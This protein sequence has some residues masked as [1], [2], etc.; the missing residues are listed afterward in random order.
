MERD[1]LP[2]FWRWPARLVRSGPISGRFLCERLFSVYPRQGRA[3][4]LLLS[5]GCG[6]VQASL[7]G[8]TASVEQDRALMRASHQVSRPARVAAYS[9]HSLQDSGG[10]TVREFADAS[11]QVFALAWNGPSLPNLQQI[12]GSHFEAYLHAPLR[13]QG[14]RGHLSVQQGPLV[15]ES[16]GRM[17]NFFGRAYLGD[18]IPAGVQL[19]EIR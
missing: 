2:G 13:H 10:G 4:A 14:G 6:N 3:I 9:V 1:C 12:L 15:V 16:G 11:G 17:R 19:D 8:D 7:G 5:L 18:R